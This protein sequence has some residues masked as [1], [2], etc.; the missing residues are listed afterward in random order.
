MALYAHLWVQ[1]SYD[2]GEVFLSF[3]RVVFKGVL[4]DVPP[5]AVQLVQSGENILGKGERGGFRKEERRGWKEEGRKRKEWGG[6]GSRRAVE[7]GGKTITSVAPC[8]T[9]A[10][11]CM[12]CLPSNHVPG[13]AT[14][15]AM[16][17]VTQH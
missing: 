8:T 7:V 2:V 10:P 17:D 9:W 15:Q 1:S 14:F 6:R 3:W 11:H 16:P 4:S 5:R 12:G 13:N